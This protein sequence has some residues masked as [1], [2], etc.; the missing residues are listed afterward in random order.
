MSTDHSARN[1]GL[2]AIAALA[3]S[4]GLTPADIEGALAGATTD[5]PTVAQLVADL[6]D[7][8]EYS[9]RTVK[10]Y[11]TGWLLLEELYGERVCSDVTVKELRAAKAEAV[12][13]AQERLVDRNVGRADKGLT[14]LDSTSHGAGENFVRAA[15]ALWQ[16]AIDDH[17]LRPEDSPAAKVAVGKRPP[18]VRRRPLERHELEQVFAA[19]AGGGNDPMLDVLLV[20]AGF[21]LGAR[22]E[23]LVNLRIMDIDLDRQTVVLYEKGSKR[24]EQPASRAL[25]VAL[26]D[27]ASQR[28]ASEPTDNVLR[29]RP[30]GGQPSRPITSR[31]FDTLYTRIR[32][33]LPAWA[34]HV[35]SHWLR[36]TA[37]RRIERIA[38][39]AVAGRFLGHKPSSVTAGYTTTLDHEVAAAW[40]EAMGEP[41]PLADDTK[42]GW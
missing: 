42:A 36:H 32:A 9:P 17:G 2:V 13:R 37:G 29:F 16:R 30:R 25:L 24:R 39:E 40:S 20:R 33:E 35:S 11:Q 22:Q 34:T 27:L 21:E 19:A 31:R 4:H 5:L 7:D 6:L 28:G 14:P 15:R 3:K 41:H 8:N 10:T 23:G 1:A 12:R 18:S 38:G 26:L